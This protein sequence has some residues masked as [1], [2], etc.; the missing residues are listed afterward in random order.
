MDKE[1]KKCKGSYTVEMAL[2]SGVWLLVIM[3]SLLLIVGNYSR[4]CD[5]ASSCEAAVF[6]ST[7]A[8]RR[9]GDGAAQTAKRL[10]G[11]QNKY[12]VS[13]NKKEITVHYQNKTEM[14]YANLKWQWNGTVKRKI[15]KPVLFIE[16][17]QQSRRFLENIKK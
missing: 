12:T 1:L 4:I 9:K 16:K 13:G 10:G 8:V 2:I 14:P 5:V 15:I 3:A 7:E 6:G 17:V 11:Q